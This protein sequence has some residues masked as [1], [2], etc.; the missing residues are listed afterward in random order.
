MKRTKLPALWWEMGHESR[1][2][3]QICSDAV[4]LSTPNIALKLEQRE[5]K[6]LE[7]SGKMQ[8]FS[9]KM[10]VT[11]G[12]NGKKF[13][14]LA[15]PLLL[16]PSLAFSATS[17][18][19]ARVV[20]VDPIYENVSYNVPVE[21]CR[22]EQVRYT[23][24]SPRRSS[25][26]APIL[27]AI[28]GGA[29]GNAVGH[30]KSNKKVGTIIGAVLGGSIGADIGRRHRGYSNGPARYRTEQ[31][32]DVVDEVRSEERLAGYNV[33]YVYAG[34]TYTTRMQRDPG[35]SVRVRVRVSPVD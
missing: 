10:V 35:T 27:G 17:Y 19:S 18:D 34:N 33:S 11:T 9:E 13:A 8:K 25:A 6:R 23:E 24:P 21:Q 3:S 29:L 15:L 1:E 5:A 14:R 22:E 4:Q 26:T 12:A 28:I 16:V 30:N 32:C 20:G 2:S 7:M 31:V